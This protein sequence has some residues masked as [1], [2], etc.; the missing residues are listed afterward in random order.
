MTYTYFLKILYLSLQDNMFKLQ[1]TNNSK[2][3]STRLVQANMLP[4]EFLLV[5]NQPFI[6]VISTIMVQSGKQ[7]S[8]FCLKYFQ[9]KASA[10]LNWSKKGLPTPLLRTMPNTEAQQ[11]DQDVLHNY[12]AKGMI[13]YLVYRLFRKEI[14]SFV[15][16]LHLSCSLFPV[17]L[18]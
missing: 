15:S 7:S 1:C 18:V 3:S 10:P 5:S 17:W 13:Q 2:P 6:L 16:D 9:M 4:P 8:S 14:A 12:I 11:R